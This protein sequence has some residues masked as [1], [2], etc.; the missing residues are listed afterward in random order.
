MPRYEIADELTEQQQIASP[1]LFASDNEE[2]TLAKLM[3][4]RK[5]FE[6]G[7][8]KPVMVDTW[9]RRNVVA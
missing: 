4:L 7:P 5:K 9:P 3:E 6:G 1:P 8:T 2:K